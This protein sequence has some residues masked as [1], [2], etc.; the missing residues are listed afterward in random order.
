MVGEGFGG[1]GMKVPT[2]YTGEEVRTCA[3]E[4]DGGRVVVD[5]EG[6]NAVEGLKMVGLI[7]VRDMFGTCTRLVS[8]L[9]ATICV[10][11]GSL[12][13]QLVDSPLVGPPN[14]LPEPPS[15]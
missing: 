6:C 14:G 2:Q 7:V 4:C 15:V 3:C 13:S 5:Q 10:D 1:T 12:T 11:L 8:P 9:Y